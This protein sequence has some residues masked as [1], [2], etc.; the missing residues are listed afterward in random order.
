[1]FVPRGQIKHDLV[2]RQTDPQSALYMVQYAIIQHFHQKSGKNEN[3]NSAPIF[4]VKH[5]MS[6]YI[7]QNVQKTIK[8]Q[9]L[10]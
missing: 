5:H 3:F 2:T 10:M 9:D 8:V 7:S 4:K 1:M 6:S